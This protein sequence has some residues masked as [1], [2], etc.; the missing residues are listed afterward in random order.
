MFQHTVAFTGTKSGTMP[1]PVYVRPV[2]ELNDNEFITASLKRIRG[3]HRLWGGCKIKWYIDN[4]NDY[5]TL[6][7]LLTAELNDSDATP[8]TLA[9]DGTTYRR[10][11][12]KSDPSIVPI[13][14]KNVGIEVE[15][16]FVFV[17]ALTAI[18]NP[19]HL[20]SGQ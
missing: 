14:D 6:S 2:Y 12:L 1:D 18:P 5:S 3:R 7:D 15:L 19:P 9:V 8:F 11:H 20:G 13:S 10:S 17:Q 4:S 16:E